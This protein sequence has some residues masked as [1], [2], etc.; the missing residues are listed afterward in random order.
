MRHYLIYEIRNILG[1]LAGVIF[2]FVFPVVIL[3]GNYFSNCA[4]L[5]DPAQVIL[6][7][8][9][10]IQCSILGPT[11]LGL[12]SLPILFAREIDTGV[13]KRAVY[14]GYSGLKQ[15][16]CKLWA[17]FI[18]IIISDVIYTTIALV[19]LPLAMPQMSA[20][21]WFSAGTVLMGVAYILIGL[22]AALLARNYQRGLGLAML[23]YF[24]SMILAGVFIPNVE[25]INATMKIIVEHFAVYEWLN[26]LVN[27]W[28]T[29]SITLV[30]HLTLFAGLLGLAV[31]LMG[32]AS[33]RIQAS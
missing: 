2:G 16:G 20:L 30:P 28:Q 23:L 12:M 9:L 11:A 22:S 10:F 15:I 29:G 6:A 24:S 1:S 31:V 4:D 26:A 13:T 18:L 33:R 32:L 21:L 7:T 14:L 3:L 17:S 25:N 8:H 19:A 5:A 27:T